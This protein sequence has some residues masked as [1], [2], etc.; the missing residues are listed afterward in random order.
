MVDDI[1]DF[2][3]EEECAAVILDALHNAAYYLNGEG[4]R[5]IFRNPVYI[6]YPR[7]DGEIPILRFYKI[8]N[9]N[10]FVQENYEALELVGVPENFLDDEMSL[11][12]L[13]QIRDGELHLGFLDQLDFNTEVEEY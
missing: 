13:K 9:V 8:V 2:D 10:N 7:I 11:D 5:G 3:T 12:K 4:S 1:K 6:Q